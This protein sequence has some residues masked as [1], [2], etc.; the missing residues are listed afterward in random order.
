MYQSFSF[1]QIIGNNPFSSLSSESV[2]LKKFSWLKYSQN[3]K[4]VN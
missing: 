4:Q 3:V 1:T 2:D